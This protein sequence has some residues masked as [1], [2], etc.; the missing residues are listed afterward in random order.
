[1]EIKQNLINY[2][3]TKEQIRTVKRVQ[4]TEILAENEDEAKKVI[5]DGIVDGK[6]YYRSMECCPEE[7]ST[8][9]L[10]SIEEKIVIEREK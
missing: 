9:T 10:L 5:I 2:K 8:D 3:I 1:M 4:I 6:K 7:R